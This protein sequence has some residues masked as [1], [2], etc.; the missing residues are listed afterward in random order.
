MPSLPQKLTRCH[1]ALDSAGVA[2]A[3]GGAIALAYWTQDPR[4]TSDLD[5]NVFVGLDRIEECLRALPAKVTCDAAA[6]TQLESEGQARLWWDETP[7]DIFLST[8]ELHSRA[9]ANIRMVNFDKGTIPV[10]GPVELA[11]FKVLF[12][13]TRDWADLESMAEAGTLDAAEVA[14]ALSGLV[15]SSDSRLQR[16]THIAAAQ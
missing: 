16:L 1:E 8:V 6:R 10:V 5:L 11:A 13:R 9:E 12:N 14:V 2:H 4:G 15:D 7:I 3:F